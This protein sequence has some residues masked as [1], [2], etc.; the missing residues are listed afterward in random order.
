MYL[1]IV[2]KYRML[3]SHPIWPFWKRPFAF[4]KEC[5][6]IVVKRR[7]TTSSGDVQQSI[8][9]L[10]KGMSP[11]PLQHL[12][13]SPPQHGCDQKKEQIQKIQ[14][15]ST[16]SRRFSSYVPSLLHNHRSF[17]CRVCFRAAILFK[18]KHPHTQILLHHEN[19]C[20]LSM[21]LLACWLL[22]AHSQLSWK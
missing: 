17:V 7:I 9:D 2:T 4:F 20:L 19:C 18:N 8:V 15:S 11:V 3:A 6:S 13:V 12:T 1:A 14:M 5:E 21:P 10:T 22:Y 16:F